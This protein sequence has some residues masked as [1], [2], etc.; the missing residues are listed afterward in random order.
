MTTF[1]RKMRRSFRPRGD[2][3]FYCFDRPDYPQQFI[4]PERFIGVV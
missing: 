3:G 4:L 1:R 2:T